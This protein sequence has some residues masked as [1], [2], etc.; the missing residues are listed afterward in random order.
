MP[1]GPA[2]L[3]EPA[4]QRPYTDHLDLPVAA[5]ERA[6]LPDG[7]SYTATITA[8]DGRPRRLRS[9]ETLIVDVVP[10]PPVT[11]TLTSNGQPVDPGATSGRRRRTWR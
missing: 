5:A 8:T 2:I 7:V 1:P 4:A 11:L 6:A 9:T 3:S 10:A